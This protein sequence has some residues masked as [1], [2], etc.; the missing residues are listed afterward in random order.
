MGKY[1]GF[2]IEEQAGIVA[3]GAYQAVLFNDLADEDMT[4][5]KCHVEIAIGTE[6]GTT[7]DLGN[8]WSITGVARLVISGRGQD[9]SG[10]ITGNNAPFDTSIAGTINDE[11]KGDTWAMSPFVLT[12]RGQPIRIELSP[13]TKRKL[14]KGDQFLVTLDG[15][16]SGADTSPAVQS[17]ATVTM[18]TVVD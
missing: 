1:Q 14:R 3:A 17:A 4:I 15:T 11:D 9:A 7:A 13:K 6:E 5:V 8:Q 16:N 18:F 2:N 10:A 12:S